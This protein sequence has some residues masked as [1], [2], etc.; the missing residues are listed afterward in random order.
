VR[1]WRP[2]KFLVEPLLTFA[3]NFIEVIPPRDL[4]RTRMGI[5]EIW[6]RSYWRANGRLPASLSDLPILGAATIPS[7]TVGVARSS[8]TSKEVQPSLFQ[9]WVLIGPLLV[10]IRM[11]LLSSGWR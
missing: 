3:R 2:I 10:L 6:I 1:V 9:A 8:T 4:T 11:T 5:T 7:L